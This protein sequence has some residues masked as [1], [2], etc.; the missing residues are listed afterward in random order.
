MSM[1]FDFLCCP[2]FTPSAPI[3]KDRTLD[4]N[5]SLSLPIKGRQSIQARQTSFKQRELGNGVKNLE[6]EKARKQ[7]KDQ[8]QK[9]DK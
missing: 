2:K 4:L 8:S 5:T 1:P 7:P 6:L 9:S 3:H